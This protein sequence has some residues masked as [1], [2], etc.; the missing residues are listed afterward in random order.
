[1]AEVVP[2][3]KRACERCGRM[4]VWDESQGKWVVAEADGREQTGTPHCLH[5]WDINGSYNPLRDDA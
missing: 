1:M 3:S 4:D 5:E 2:P